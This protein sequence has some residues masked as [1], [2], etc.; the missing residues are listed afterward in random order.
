M[1]VDWQLVAATGTFLAALAA[2]FTA[3]LIYRARPLAI[4]AV[5]LHSL[6]LQQ[7]VLPAWK[8][9][10]PRCP[11]I[12]D[13]DVDEHRF[14]DEALDQLEASAL[15]QD[16]ANHIPPG[17]HLMLLRRKYRKDWESLEK[18]RSAF[19]R[20]V[21]DCVGQA[22]KHVGIMVGSDRDMNAIIE[23]QFVNKFYNSVTHLAEGCADWYEVLKHDA[24]NLSLE[25]GTGRYGLWTSGYCWA[26]VDGETRAV[27]A[28]E[29]FKKLC[30][31]LPLI[32]PIGESVSLLDESRR[33]YA[34]KS[35]LE[36]LCGQIECAIDA[37][38]AL[39]LLP[40]THC[41]LL[42]IAIEP[43]TPRWMTKLVSWC[44]QH[45]PKTKNIGQ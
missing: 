24:A 39:P 38:V 15:F 20:K 28:K 23:H 7:E 13:Y 42:Q 8:S 29:F 40:N 32:Q 3:W 18:S 5:E 22:G 30:D 41:P 44:S 9:L 19:A 45:R 14:S 6:K 37:L 33:L 1:G 21:K 17:N 10:L 34:D 12:V 36:R 43:L 26:F 4:R 31:E 27:R 35:S 25:G 16:L 11:N 2:L